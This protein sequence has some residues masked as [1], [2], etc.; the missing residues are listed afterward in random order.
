MSNTEIMTI[1]I[2]FRQSHYRDFKN[3]YL[4]YIAKYLKAYFPSLL[5][6]T[7]FIVIMPSV[8]IPLNPYL[9]TLFGKGTIG[10]FFGF[11]LHLIINHLG[12]IMSVKITE[13]KYK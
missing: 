13:G 10:W 7:R 1:I 5:S 4:G 3:Y 12:E 9:T 8:I 6:Y 11:K 2:H